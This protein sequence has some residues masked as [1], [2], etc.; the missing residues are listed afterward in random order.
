MNV[1]LDQISLKLE[2]MTQIPRG[3]LEKVQKKWVKEK[4]YITKKPRAIEEQ[5]LKPIKEKPIQAHH[6]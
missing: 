1:K 3:R 4:R 5:L 2:D 6:K